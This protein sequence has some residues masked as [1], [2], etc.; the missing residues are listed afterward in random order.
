MTLVSEPHFTIDIQ[1][2]CIDCGRSLEFDPRP[3]KGVKDK[4]LAPGNTRRQ[5]GLPDEMQHQ[6]PV[7]CESCRTAHS[8]K[9]ARR[10]RQLPWLIAFAMI[11]LAL[12][13]WLLLK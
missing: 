12:A 10:K 1:E 6:R 7:R 13:L 5:M 8:E 3:F 4:P 9:W 11:L 2:S